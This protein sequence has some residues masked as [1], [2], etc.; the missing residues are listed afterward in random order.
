M[1]IVYLLPLSL[2]STRHV[3]DIVYLLKK[4]SIVRLLLTTLD[5]WKSRGIGRNVFYI[6]T[7]LRDRDRQRSTKIAVE[8]KI[9]SISLSIIFNFGQNFLHVW[10]LN[11]CLSVGNSPGDMLPKVLN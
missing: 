9:Y 11:V 10:S 1:K 2:P 6:E 5:L 3:G 8:G 7:I 4:G